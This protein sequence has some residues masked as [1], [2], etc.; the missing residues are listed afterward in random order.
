LEDLAKA[1][2]EVNKRLAQ[3]LVHADG[4]PGHGKAQTQALDNLNGAIAQVEKYCR[5]DPKTAAVIAAATALAARA[6]QAL[7]QFCVETELCF[8]P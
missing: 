1:E 8:V 2:Y 4:D 3:Y 7:Q 6:A 5:C